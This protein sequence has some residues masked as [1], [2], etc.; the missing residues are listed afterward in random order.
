MRVATLFKRLLGFDAVS[1]ARIEVVERCG[2][3]VVEVEVTR[4]RNRRMFCS[5]CGERCTAIY[6][7][8]VRSWRH[9]DVFRVRCIVKAEV[10][11]VSCPGCGVKPEVVP[12]ARAGARVTRAFEDT[13]VWLARSAPKSVV[14]EIQRVDW[15]SVGV[16]IARVVAE[17]TATRS[18]DGWTASPGSGLMR[19]PTAK[20]IAT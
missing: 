1:V 5:G 19:S 10:R 15:H 13:C 12:W 18:G 6:D 3:Q 2:E 9:L 16:M 11:R 14:A 7:R 8:S 20:A 17:H 4:R